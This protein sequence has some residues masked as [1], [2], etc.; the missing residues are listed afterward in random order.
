LT[1][2]QPSETGCLICVDSASAE[3]NIICSYLPTSA[4]SCLV[5]DLFAQ[6][7]W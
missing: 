3:I 7:F 6:N 2:S 5:Q 1:T 4:H